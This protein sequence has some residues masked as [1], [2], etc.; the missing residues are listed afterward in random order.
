[1]RVVIWILGTSG[2]ILCSS[3]FAG[4]HGVIGPTFP[5]PVITAT[6]PD[7]IVTGQPA[8]YV[9]YG[10]AGFGVF[11][12][13]DSTSWV[14]GGGVA[15]DTSAQAQPTVTAG[16]PGTYHGVVTLHNPSGDVTLDFT[17]T[18]TAQ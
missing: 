15:P 7:T 11:T 9:A 18:V 5:D 4:P 10:Y 17:Y 13:T 2:I 6:D 16:A 12:L 1:M 3:C 8:T 14:F